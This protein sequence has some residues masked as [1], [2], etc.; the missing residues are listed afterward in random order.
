MQVKLRFPWFAPTVHLG[1]AGGRMSGHY[2]AAGVHE[3]E[4]VWKNYLPTGSEII[5]SEEEKEDKTVEEDKVVEK[6][7]EVPVDFCVPKPSVTKKVT[8][9]KKK[10]DK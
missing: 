6:E 10:K 2:Y 5:Y 9:Y 3:I 4:T 8:S 7:E 1:T